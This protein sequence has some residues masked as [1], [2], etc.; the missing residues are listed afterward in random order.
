MSLQDVTICITSFLRPGYLLRA[1]RDIKANLPECSVVIVDDGDVKLTFPTEAGGSPLILMPFDSGLSAKRN[2]GVKATKTKYWLNGCDDFD[3]STA[4]ARQ[5]IEKLVKILD[6]HADVDVAG[7]R[8]DNNPYEGYLEYKPGEF[9]REH[10]AEIPALAKYVK[11][12]LTVNYFLART[13]KILDWD[14]RMKIGGEHGDWFLSMKDA[15]RKVVY[16]PGVNI[17]T[18][19]LDATPE[20]I[21]PRY[22]RFRSRARGLGHK[23]FKEKR[24]IKDYIGFDGEKS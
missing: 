11:V 9:I 16:V 5:G 14:E 7:G 3:F 4:D 20:N 17:N 18:F 8:A 10:R 23:I 6:E 13:D 12:D 15:G 1:L 22:G 21:D 2:E 19:H 24:N